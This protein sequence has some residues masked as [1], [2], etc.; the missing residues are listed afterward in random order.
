[1]LEGA[2]QLAD[3]QLVSPGA[4]GS[5]QKWTHVVALACKGRVLAKLDRHPEAL[6]SFDAAIA[7]SKESYIMMR[8][9]AYRELAQYADPAAASAAAG[10]AKDLEITLHEFE[11]RLTAAD[12]GRLRIAP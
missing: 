9:L 10:A 3:S 12:F 2:L 8:A 11:G 1:M 6:A 5:A 4:G 7:A